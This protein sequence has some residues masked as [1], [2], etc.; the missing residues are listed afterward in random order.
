MGV[1][2]GCCVATPMGLC[3]GS[4]LLSDRAGHQHDSR[5]SDRLSRTRLAVSGSWIKST[6]PAR[7]PPARETS[8]L[9]HFAQYHSGRTLSSWRRTCLTRG[10]CLELPQKTGNIRATPADRRYRCL[11]SI[12]RVDWPN[13]VTAIGVIGACGTSSVGKAACDRI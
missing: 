11:A 2:L 8:H 6:R 12:P 4:A 13:S 5:T 7:S 3:V 9:L 10:L 1:R